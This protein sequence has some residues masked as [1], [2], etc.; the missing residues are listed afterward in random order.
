[1]GGLTGA[2]GFELQLKPM[3]DPAADKYIL[4]PVLND[5]AGLISTLTTNDVDVANSVWGTSNG[6]RFEGASGGADAVETTLQPVDPTTSDNTILL[7]DNSVALLGVNTTVQA[8]TAA[9]TVLTT[10]QGYG[11]VCTVD[12]TLQTPTVVTLPTPAVGMHIV[13]TVIVTNANDLRI[14]PGAHDILHTSAAGD[15]LVLAG[16]T[17]GDCITLIGISA[18]QWVAQI[19]QGTWTEE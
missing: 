7:P 18:T 11:V 10:K 19:G 1:M 12:T 16:P 14:E 8:C 6:L 9:D 5:A 17:V 4:F 13:I 15:Y 2:D 3:G